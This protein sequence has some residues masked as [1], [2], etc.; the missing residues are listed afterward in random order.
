MRVEVICTG[1]EVLSGATVNTN[2]SFISRQLYDAGLPVH[3]ETTV[4]DD[5]ESLLE[6]FRLAGTRADAVI[7]N[8]GLGP[9]V[10]DLSQETAAQAAG[11]GLALDDAWLARMENH[12]RLRSRIM[13]PNNRK[14][15]MLPVGAEVLDNPVGTACGFAID[16]GRARFFFTPGVPRE[17]RRMIDE[18]VLPRILARS[19]TA[20]AV[21][22]KRFHSFGIG[23]SR[24]DVLLAGVEALAPEGSVK[25]GFRAHYPQLETK[26][27]LRGASQAELRERLAPVAAA[28]RERLGNFI[29]AEDEQ[30]LED[31][32]LATLHKAGLTLAIAED[33]TSG[34]VATRL[35]VLEGG[36]AV[37]RRSVAA[38]DRAALAAAVDAARTG[39]TRAARDA[40]SADTDATGAGI[41]S[42]LRQLAGTDLALAIMVEPDSGADR[43]DFGGHVE[44]AIA[45]ETGVVIRRSRLVG[46]REWLRLGAAEMAL[47]ALRRHLGGLPIDE[48]IDFEKLPE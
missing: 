37:L 25:L 45:R 41:A 39:S 7:V 20:Q 12:F 46:G 47:D 19:G 40:D 14:Q 26:L 16:I 4:G 48:R 44:I 29:L 34:R 5:R 28:V 8:G 18:Q 17:M 35:A 13:P 21:L 9:T 31:M 23:E 38:P 10:D 1:D 24:A 15:A 30:T 27:A 22:L 32:L 43:T 2:F 3:W 36:G 33:Y 42:A 11:V 6:A